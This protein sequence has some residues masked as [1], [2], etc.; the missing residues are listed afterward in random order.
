MV[1]K[2]IKKVAVGSGHVLALTDD[3]EVYGWGRND[4]GQVGETSETNVSEPTLLT[5]LQGKNIVDI[6]CG[7]NQVCRKKWRF[8]IYIY[9]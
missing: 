2:C 1:G 3:G 6:D 4:N 8:I 7:P 9:M 5:L